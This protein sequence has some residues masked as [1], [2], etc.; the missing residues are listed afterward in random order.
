MAM[1]KVEDR[2]TIQLLAEKKGLK[3]SNVKGTEGVQLTTGNNPRLAFISWDDFF[4]ALD[5][6]GLAVYR[7]GGWLKIMKA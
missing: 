5:A 3:P 6:R 7:S 1:E 4:N 2:K